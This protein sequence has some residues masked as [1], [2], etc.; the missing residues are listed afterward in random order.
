MLERLWR[1]GLT[2]AVAA[3]AAV[4]AVV[5]AAVAA[6]LAMPEDAEAVHVSVSVP[7]VAAEAAVVP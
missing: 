4:A 2:S 1:Q 5:D 6:A 7:G 3:V